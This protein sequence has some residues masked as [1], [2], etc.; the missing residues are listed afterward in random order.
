MRRFEFISGSSS[1][2]WSP[3]VEGA[4][5]IVVFGRI[6]TAGQRKEKAF[7]SEAEARREM[8]KKVAEKLREGYA[9]V[10]GAPAATAPPPPPAEAPIPELPPRFVRPRAATAPAGDRRASP[11]RESR[12]GSAAIE[13]V[14][15]ATQA[16]QELKAALQHQKA[17]SWAVGRRLRVARRALWAIA[18]YQ[19]EQNKAFAAALDAL[20]SMTPAPRR[21][22]LSVRAALSLL[23]LLDAS[24]L[25]R[26]LEQ[27][28]DKAPAAL[29]RQRELLG[30]GEL[31]L[32]LSGLLLFRPDAGYGSEGAWLREW[33]GVAPHLASVLKRGGGS[34]GEYLAQADAGDTSVAERAA[35]MIKTAK[36]APR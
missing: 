16:L 21:P 19:P 1:K 15:A 34:L 30:E 27:W 28:G 3:E 33:Q 8:E 14:K 7:P 20:L 12:R 17:R 22:R 31:A 6:G 24:A 18:G 4:N 25:K 23:L 2:F 35:R 32:R 11:D 13:Q 36:T 26:A 29:R 5:F 9:E 10:G